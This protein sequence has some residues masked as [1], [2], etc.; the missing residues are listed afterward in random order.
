MR[1]LGHV[2]PRNNLAGQW[3]LLQD[4][5][6]M[7]QKRIDLQQQPLSL[8]ELTLNLALKYQ[9]TLFPLRLN[10]INPNSRVAS[11]KPYICKK[12][13]M[14]WLKF[15]TEYVIWMDEQ[16]DCV[17]FSDES[18]FNLFGCDGKPFVRRSPKERYSP[19]GTK[20]SIKF[21]GVI[22]MVFGM[23]SA[24]GIGLFVWLHGK[25]NAT[26][27]K[28]ILKKHAVPIL[29]TAINQ[30]AVFM[31]DNA[32]CHATKSVKTFL[33]KKDVAVIEW[34][35]QIPDMNPIENVW[36][37]LNERLNEQNPRNVEELWTNFKGEWEK[38]CVD[39]CKTLIHSRSKR[40]QP[41]IKSKSLHI[42][43]K[44]ITN[45]IFI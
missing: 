6:I 28:E 45:A 10:E 40:W 43:Y 5:L 34:P 19:L 11:T 41:V 44:G 25:I 15:A 4:G 7:N 8:K 1:K 16:C 21:G 39:E 42:K 26:A 30:P 31:Q 18:K 37:L 12:N 36:K 38:I 14:S 22:V 17:H 20:S 3:K 27:Y 23:I 13:K 24:A 29:R 35:A 2:K 32:P 9:G 33:S